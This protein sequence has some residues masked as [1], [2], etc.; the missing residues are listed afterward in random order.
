MSQATT[1]AA[2][3]E[4]KCDF[5]LAGF[6]VSLEALKDTVP[7][8]KADLKK[9]VEEFKTALEELKT[10]LGM[11]VVKNSVRASSNVQAHY[12]YV[13]NTSVLKGHRATYSYY[14]QIDDLDLVSKVYDALTSFKEV[15]TSSPSYSIKDSTRERLNKKAL[16]HAF[17]KVTDRL[18][19]ECEVLGLTPADFEIFS[20]ETGY[21]DSQRHDRVG[22]RRAM[23]GSGVAMAM[24]APASADDAGEGATL[25]DSLE[26]VAG[27][28]TVYVNLEVGYSR[29]QVS[30]QAVKAEVVS[31]S[32]RATSASV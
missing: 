9:K 30:A 12:E 13:K 11:E 32:T 5:N 8:A 16:K 15:R 29:K 4:A 28:A 3:G 23:G 26:L 24:M 21:S 7:L 22:A 18:A 27:Q 31:K 19:T 2:Q 17:E 25:D 20:W 6:S 14:F 1:I 10:K